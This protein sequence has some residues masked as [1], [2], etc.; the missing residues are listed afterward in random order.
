MLRSHKPKKKLENRN[1][2]P[3]HSEATRQKLL[4]IA[5]PIFA[6]KGYYTATIREISKQAGANVAA[7]NYHFKGKLGL[8]VEVLNQ[9]ARAAHVEKM[10]AALEQTGSSY[11]DILR[12]VIRARVQGL[13]K[14]AAPDWHVQLFVRELTQPTPA[15]S[16]MINKVS[17]PIY[18]RLLDLLGKIIG[19]PPDHEKTRLC[20]QSI[21][22]QILFH[23]FAGPVLAKLSP[24][25][26]TTPERL[27]QIANHIADF[28][29]AYLRETARAVNKELIN[30]IEV[31]HD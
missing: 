30:A 19:L 27:D 7:V 9:C 4:R 22:G 23:A 28:S 12:D 10:R 17:R 31:K 6:E 14:G 2:E 8:Y 26:K 25:T 11:D 20:A 1:R 18:E 13:C 15:M 16:L 21:M 3:G 29:L 5:G 24:E